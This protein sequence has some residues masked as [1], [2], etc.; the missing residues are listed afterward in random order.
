[1]SPI[2]VALT[3]FAI[4]LIL[5]ITAFDETFIILAVIYSVLAYLTAILT[6]IINKYMSN[7]D[8]NNTGCCLDN[9]GIDESNVDCGCSRSEIIVD[10]NYG[11]KRCWKSSIH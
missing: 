2:L 5:A 3:A 1:M 10:K 7:V 8:N 4:F 6:K 9:G 11:N